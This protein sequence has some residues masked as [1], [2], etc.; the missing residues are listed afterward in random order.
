MLIRP[1]TIIQSKV[2]HLNGNGNGKEQ[3]DG[4]TEAEAAEAEDKG[5]SNN[6]EMEEDQ[7]THNGIF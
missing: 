6:P 5:L 4:R 2:E 1:L 7:Q 3:R